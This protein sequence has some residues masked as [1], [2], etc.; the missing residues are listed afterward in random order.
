[1]LNYFESELLSELPLEDAVDKLEFPDG[2]EIT[3]KEEIK[4]FLEGLTWG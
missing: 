2:T 4:T 3:D 1:M